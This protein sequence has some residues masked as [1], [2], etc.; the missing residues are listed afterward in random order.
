MKM[1]EKRMHG[2]FTLQFNLNDP[3]Q[4]EVARILETK[5]RHKSAFIT[6][7]IQNYTKNAIL[8]QTM[9]EAL[10]ERIRAA[11]A[12]QSE[13]EKSVI[14]DT[15]AEGAAEVDNTAQNDSKSG[16]E[17]YDAIRQTMLAF[18]NQ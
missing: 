16:A 18:D 6:E 12:R 10:D 8:M 15:V 9:G 11:I 7:A 3:A 17:D 4:A 13:A 2:R 1:V 5:G 14:C